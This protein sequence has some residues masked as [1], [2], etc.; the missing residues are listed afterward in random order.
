MGDSAR[1]ALSA[2]SATAPG[3]A[4][5]A[6]AACRAAIS[7]KARSTAAAVVS[8]PAAEEVA[9]RAVAA[10]E[11][12]SRPAAAVEGAGAAEAAAVDDVEG[13]VIVRARSAVVF[14]LGL[15]AMAGPG[16]VAGSAAPP[17]ISASP[18]AQTF[19]TA[20]EA[21]TALVGTLRTDKPGALNTVLG[22]GS[23]KL[24]SSG[25]KYSDA[26]ERQ[27]FLAAYDQSHKLVPAEPEHMILQVGKNDWPFPIPLVQAAGRWHFD[28]QAGADELVNRRIG[29]NE[30]AAIRTSLAYVDAQK[31]FFAFTAQNGQ[32]EYAQ[33]LA[34]SPGKHNGL[35]WPAAEGGA[36]SPLA[37]L[38][39]QAQEE[40]YPGE[41][42]AG[43]PL[44]Y[45][46]YY[47]RI[48]TGQGT[49][50]AEGARDYLSGG[51]MTKGFALIAWPASYGA[52]GIMT[53][54]VN[55]DGIVFQKDLGP[56]TAVAAAAIKLFDPDLSW[57]RVD[58]VN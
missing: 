51:R 40:G 29:R 19:G 30:I 12:V 39:A 43:R 54:I 49:S 17:Q 6:L 27:K 28:S 18:T 48:L 44:P 3:P 23:E 37:P 24:I 14:L 35:Y 8:R 50:A 58:I 33:R 1:Q 53:F 55:Q 46:G 11:A 15:C 2:G 21:V 13:R 4:N 5:M 32:G 47:F 56:N 16:S 9:F 10:A 34:S 20:E 26:A 42:V 52:S 45:H 41:R 22:P 7:N 25:D 36:E 57:A 31:A 38:M